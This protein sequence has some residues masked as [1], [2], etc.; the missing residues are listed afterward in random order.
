M[1]AFVLQRKMLVVYFCFLTIGAG[2]LSAVEK[3]SGSREVTSIA[4][5]QDL[6][7]IIG[8]GSLTKGRNTISDDSKNW[9]P[10]SLA[11]KCVVV[12]TETHRVIDNS[13]NRLML[14]GVW[15]LNN[16]TYDY[17]VAD[18]VIAGKQPAKEQPQKASG[19]GMSKGKKVAIGVAAGGAAAG[20][21][22]YMATRSD[23]TKSG[24]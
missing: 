14:E 7:K 20:F 19:Q 22:A 24:D 2:S 12:G 3:S 9:A 18:C 10:Q 8:N 6:Q 13:K 4:A 17:T 11:N 5:S 16:G 1:H 15:M 23:E 21:G